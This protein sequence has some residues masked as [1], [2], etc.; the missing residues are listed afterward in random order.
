MSINKN[1]YFDDTHPLYPYTYSLPANE[2]SLPPKNALRK[3]PTFMEGYWP[4]MQDGNWVLLEDHR[5][6]KYW[7]NTD[8]YEDDP[9]IITTLGPLPENIV[10]NRPEKPENEIRK[11][12]AL[13]LRQ[14]RDSLLI[15]SD[16][17]MLVD[18]P[19]DNDLLSK[20]K[21]YRKALRDMPTLEGFPW[22]GG[23]E[24]DLEC[25]WPEKPE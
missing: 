12:L 16:K 1:Y 19:I 6:T 13:A 20:W 11:E 21:T 17:Y 18:Y 4:C 22:N 9:K 10:F 2:N 14:K 3:K 5:G 7:N 24:D 15:E 25:P 23:G 8:T